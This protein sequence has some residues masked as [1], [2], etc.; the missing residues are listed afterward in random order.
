MSE[1]FKAINA[2]MQEVGYV[3]KKR[4]GGVN[5]SF[6]GEAALIEAIRP[7]LVKN[8]LFVFPASIRETS[9][10]YTT[11]KGATMNRA[12]LVITYRFAHTSGETF[13]VE[14]AGEGAD[15]GDKS[16]NKAM[17]GAYKYALRQTFCIETGDDPDKSAS[18]PAAPS[19]TRVPPKTNGR[20]PAPPPFANE[21]GKVND[22]GPMLAATKRQLHQLGSEVYGPDWKDQLGKFQAY[23]KLLPGEE[24][25]EAQA[26]KLISG[27]LEKLDPA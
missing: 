16:F 27:M 1:I 7:E 2:V 20:N 13:D 23:Y 5:Y 22:N 4:S 26:Q 18:E 3:Q 17:T 12:V 14:V 8:G 10:S 19:V 25:T 15:V 11:S 24:F 21:G 9:D 6:A